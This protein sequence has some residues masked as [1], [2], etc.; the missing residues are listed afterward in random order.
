VK[1]D[2]LYK[3]GMKPCVF[4]V[5]E[6]QQ[7]GKG[8]HRGGFNV[9]YEKNPHSEKEIP[10]FL[11]TDRR[12][13]F[14]TLSFSYTFNFSHDTVYFSH[15]YPYSYSKLCTLLYNLQQVEKN[16]NNF[17]IEKVCYTLASMR[18]ILICITMI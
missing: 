7:N 14:A 17:K 15:S 8:W 5:G 4:S 12:K 16:Q 3:E 2:S 13:D 9:Q 1:I 6:N 18:K 10:P 11:Q